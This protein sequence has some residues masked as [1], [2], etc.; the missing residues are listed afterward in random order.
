MSCWAKSKHLKNDIWDISTTVDMTQ[1]RFF[2]MWV[3]IYII[4]YLNKSHAL[5]ERRGFFPDKRFCPSGT[6][7]HRQALPNWIYYYEKHN[8][9]TFRRELLFSC[10]MLIYAKSDF[11]W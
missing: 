8:N 4:T 6:D 7:L 5:G 3:N 10:G 11:V 1:T 9:E 2:K